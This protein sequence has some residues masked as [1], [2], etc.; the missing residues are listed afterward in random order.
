MTK[1]GFIFDLDGVIVDTAKY[2][3]LAWKKLAKRIGMD[4][5]E[6]QNE[7]LKGVSRKRSLEKILAWGNKTL[8]EAEFNQLMSA[9]NDDYLS[10]IE[11]MDDSEVLPDIAKT[12]DF[13]IGKGQAVAL[14]SASKNAV[15]ILKKVHLLD[16][17]EAIV[18]GNDVS[19]AKPDPEVFLNASELLK[20]KPED[21]IVF[22]DSV[23]GVQAANIAKMLSIGIGDKKNLHEADYV[24]K[25]FTEISEDFLNDIMSNKINKSSNTTVK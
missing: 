13:L 15:P 9:K 12:L 2:H 23:A 7:Q 20:V 24:F 8:S 19:K 25:D 21:C 16:K 10:Y 4:F 11:K 17:F 3:F 5:S 18:D 6:T 14:G 1:K 22:E